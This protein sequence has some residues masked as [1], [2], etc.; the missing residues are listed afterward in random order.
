MEYS[1]VPAGHTADYMI[2]GS[3]VA[4]VAAFAVS[5]S[6]FAYRGIIQII[7]LVLLTICIYIAIRYR[8]TVFRYLISEENGEALLT[9]Y[10]KQGRRSIAECRISLLYLKSA[11][12]YFSG[13]ELKKARRVT[14][15]YNY[16]ASI[17][18][19]RL[20]FAVFDNGGEKKTGIILEPDDTFY[21]ALCDY[22]PETP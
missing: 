7:G 3:F 11:V 21:R 6:D 17:E 14:A 18:P 13:G 20:C 12:L 8:F 4:S 16:S 10:R 5:F 15:F 1:P 22:L 19:K 2:I 9:V